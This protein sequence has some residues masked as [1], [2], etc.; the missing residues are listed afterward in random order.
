MEKAD[1]Y[2]LYDSAYSGMRKSILSGVGRDCLTNRDMAFICRYAC[3]YYLRWGPKQI[4]RKLNLQFLRMM[5][6]DNLVK[7]ITFPSEISA[8]EKRTYLFTLMYPE[9]FGPYHKEFFVITFYRAVLSG[10]RQKFPRSFFS[11]SQGA[12]QNARI[13]LMYALSTYAGCRTAA[14][15][16][17]FMTSPLAPSFLKKAKLYYVMKRKYQTPPAYVRDA[18]A[19]AGLCQPDWLYL[20]FGGMTQADCADIAAYL[21]KAFDA[22][23]CKHQGQ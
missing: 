20:R 8:P 18:L 22:C 16:I 13:C 19:M 21:I 4:A 9:I 17:E 1:L 14:E 5:K 11:G 6:L 2:Y 23:F 3:E 12:D 7:K 15:C 10:E